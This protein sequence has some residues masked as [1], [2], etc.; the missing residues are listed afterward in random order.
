MQITTTNPGAVVTAGPGERLGDCP[1]E[2]IR[3]LLAEQAWVYFAGFD[4]GLEDFDAF[5]ARFGRSTPP[6]RM[7]EMSGA[8]PLGFHAEDSYNAWRPDALWFL[9]LQTGTEGGTP[10]DVMDGVELL[11]NLDE[12]WRTFALENTV[13][14][15]QTWSKDEWEQALKYGDR[16]DIEKFLESLPDVTYEFKPDGTLFTRTEMPMY[17]ITRTGEKSFSNTMLH[18]AVQQE[19]YG[20]TLADGSPVPP[21][22][23]AHVEEK[24]IAARV[25]LGWGRGDVAVID[26]NRLMHRRGVY[27]GTGR[28]VRVIHGETFFGTEMPDTTSPVA[29]KMKEVLQGELELR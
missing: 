19:Y 11:A 22:F 27:L 6:R 1:T 13:C 3:A 29:A 14:Y 12:K 7:P 18:A 24:A 25:P 26:N 21:E 23:L 16:A 2:Q 20:M 15:N 4:A 10:T 28:D 8:V 17:A 9:C 5:A